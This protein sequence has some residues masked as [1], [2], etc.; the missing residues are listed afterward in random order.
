[1]V[2][3]RRFAAVGN[4]DGVHRGHKHLLSLARTAADEIGAELGV[5]LFDPHPRRYFRPN[6]PPFLLTTGAQR[7][8]WLRQAGAKFISTLN[9]DSALV[10]TPAEEF[11]RVTL[12]RTL[13]LSGVAVGEDFR[14][15]KGRA[16]DASMIKKIADGAGV[17]AVIVPPL[18]DGAEKFGSTSVR[19][20]IA[21]GDMAAAAAMLGRLWSVVGHVQ[22]GRQIGRTI[23][24]PTANLT[25]GPVIEPRRGV[26]A[27]RVCESGEWRDGVANFGRR[28]TVENGPPL[29]EV[30]LMDFNRDLY[31]RE[32]EVAFKAFIRDEMKFDNVDSLK[33]QIAQDCTAAKRILMRDE[34]ETIA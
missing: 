33:A 25:L 7:N 20:A 28:P 27:V 17:R 21:G 2:K 8:F 4:F 1:M 11:V 23:G 31:G 19:R 16:G 32:I 5:V 12:F 14:F 30:H 13:L 22:K 18:M 29:L 34:Q 10:E 24:F 9:F 3:N 26:Y 15:G 6:D